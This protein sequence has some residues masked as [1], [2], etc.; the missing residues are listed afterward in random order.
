M[1]IKKWTRLGVYT[2]NKFWRCFQVDLFRS[3]VT[4]IWTR[5]RESDT[6][7]SAT[8]IKI[9]RQNITLNSKNALQ[10]VSTGQLG[11]KR[12]TINNNNKKA[13]I[14]DWNSLKHMLWI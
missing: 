9:G 3:L 5:L 13:C 14:R 2:N 6:F 11:T 8:Y 10:I 12:K 4:L 7:L 1:F